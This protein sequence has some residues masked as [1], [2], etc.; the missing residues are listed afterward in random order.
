MSRT[1]A[2]Q[3]ASGVWVLTALVLVITG[4]LAYSNDPAS[5]DTVLESLLLFSFCTV[6]ALI[7]SRCPGNAI[8]WLF[9]SG[10]L[11]WALG[12]LAL[13]Y[14]VYALVSAPGSLPAGAWISW[15]GVWA[16]GMGWFAI[17]TFMLLLFPDGRLPSPRWRP[18][19]WGAAG[20]MVFFTIAIWLS[21]VSN[22]L[23]LSSVPNPLG[24]N[25][26]F[27]SILLDI[28]NLA[29]PVLLGAGGAAVLS[30]FRRARGDERQQIKWFAYAIVVMVVLFGCWFALGLAGLVTIGPLLF[31]VPLL[32]LPGAVGIAILRYRLYDIDIIINRT[33]VYGSLT[34]S[35]ALVYFGGV[36]S[37]QALFQT[38][39]G[40]QRLPQLAVV[41]STLALAALFAPLRR[42]FQS[43]I[44]RRFYRRKYDAARTLAVFS[45]K[46]RDETDLDQLSGDLV[47]VVRETVQPEH[48]SLWLREPE[49][50]A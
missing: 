44:D 14:G 5:F 24:S 46:L 47:R 12:E 40:Q 37:I 22:D 49:K 31:I 26:R 39:T 43:F 30:R 8:G 3:L 36:A 45:T 7:S 17:A 42:R 10:A 15:F 27:M 19:L 35:L 18:V 32:G 1:Q 48:V 9:C 6:G 28:A 38:L 20:Y 2:R 21:P 41:I 50:P 13:E 29:S 25:L 16:R 23:R 34:V 33:L 11:V 4:Y